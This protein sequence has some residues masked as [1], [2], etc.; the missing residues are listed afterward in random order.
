MIQPDHSYSFTDK[1]TFTILASTSFFRAL[2]R[3]LRDGMRIQESFD[4]LFG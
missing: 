1:S 2:P 4:D 3:G